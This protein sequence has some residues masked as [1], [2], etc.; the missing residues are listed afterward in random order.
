MKQLNLLIPDQLELQQFNFEVQTNKL[1]AKLLESTCRLFL[2]T[3]MFFYTVLHIVVVLWFDSVTLY[4]SKPTLWCYF[5]SLILS[6]CM[7]E[8]CCLI[9]SLV[10]CIKILGHSY[11][12]CALYYEEG[13]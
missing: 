3:V 7:S 11:P 5:S 8:L 12:P 13:I 6:G 2:K 1:G 10:M 4:Q 9:K